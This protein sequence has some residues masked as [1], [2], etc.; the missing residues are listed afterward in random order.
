MDGRVAGSLY[1]FLFMFSPQ[2]CFV[3][4]VTNFRWIGGIFPSIV[5][6]GKPPRFLGLFIFNQREDCIHMV[7]C[8]HYISYKPNKNVQLCGE[9]II[10]TAEILK[11]PQSQP[12]THYT[13]HGVTIGQRLHSCPQS[14]LV[15]DYQEIVVAD[16]VPQQW[17]LHWTDR[18]AQGNDQVRIAKYKSHYIYCHQVFSC[19]Y[20]RKGAISRGI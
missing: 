9:V 2:K 13:Q 3:K 20:P 1:D 17:Q 8:C 19:G 7:R 15:Q 6:I 10:N 14:L 12:E 18:E 4:V 5:Y 16:I 11:E